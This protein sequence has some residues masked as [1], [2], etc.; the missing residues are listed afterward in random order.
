MGCADKGLQSRFK[1]SKKK[2]NFCRKLNKSENRGGRLSKLRDRLSWHLEQ[3]VSDHDAEL[4]T[5]TTPDLPDEFNA[6]SSSSD[7]ISYTY[8][9]ASTSSSDPI[10]FT[11]NDI[12][13]VLGTNKSLLTDSEISGKRYAWRI[14]HGVLDQGSSTFSQGNI[15]IGMEFASK[16]SDHLICHCGDEFGGLFKGTG[17]GRYVVYKC[18]GCG[19]ELSS[20]TKKKVSHITRQ[21]HF[22]INLAKVCN[23]ILNDN[24]HDGYVNEC[25]SENI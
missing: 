6:S 20:A 24:G 15:N 4:P 7:P 13:L 10:V 11:S 17:H 18:E 1:R 5:S 25:I 19:H 12:D 14:N 9:I 16:I 8:P 23:S 3:N 2:N 21:K 22:E